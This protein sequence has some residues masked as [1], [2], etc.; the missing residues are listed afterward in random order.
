M[1]LVVK[2]DF[3]IINIGFGSRKLV[4][5]P[6]TNDLSTKIM[7]SVREMTNYF[8]KVRDI[9]ITFFPGSWG[10]PGPPSPG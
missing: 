3:D 5:V 2:S 9:M 1:S 8:P 6:T 4:V 7:I 10:G